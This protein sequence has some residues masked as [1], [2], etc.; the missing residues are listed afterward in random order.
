MTL[1]LRRWIRHPS[2]TLLLVQLAALLLYPFIGGSRAGQVAS[3][4]ISVGVLSAA[5]WMVHRSP[6]PGWIAGV[7]S[8]AGVGAWAAYNAFDVPWMGALGAA[9]YAAAYFYAA[10]SLI[11]YM[12]ADRHATRDEL[13]AAGAT[14]MLFVEAYAWVFVLCQWWQPDA[15]LAPG[16]AHRPLVWIELLFL[17]ATNFSATGLSDVLPLTPVARVAAVIAQWNGVMYMALIV[18]RL[19]GMI[20]SGSGSGSSSSSGSGGSADSGGRGD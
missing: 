15:F 8:V 11:T 19:A 14:F 17:S 6:R 10:F 12:M 16:G 4:A 5:V 9:G 7:L 2:R 20:G 3:T 13:W 1:P 18:S